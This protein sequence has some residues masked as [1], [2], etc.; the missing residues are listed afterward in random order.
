MHC[1]MYMYSK[2]ESNPVQIDDTG[3][4]NI[5]AFKIV[6][7]QK[8]LFCQPSHGL[9]VIHHNSSVI[10]SKLFSLFSPSLFLRLSPNTDI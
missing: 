4:K 1:N 5:S 3:C 2:V 10:N 6:A 9:L 7:G 8:S